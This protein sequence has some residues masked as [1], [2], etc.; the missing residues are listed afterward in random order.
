MVLAKQKV[1]T[2]AVKSAVPNECTPPPPSSLSEGFPPCR[3]LRPSSGGEHTVIQLIH[4]GDDD[5]LMNETRWKP[6]TE[7]RCPTL[8]DKC[9]DMAGYTKTFDYLVM[10]H[11]WESQSAP[12]RG[13]FEP[14]SVTSRFPVEH[15]NHQTTMTPPP[16]PP[17]R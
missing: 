14:L 12:A 9:T 13:R 1:F 16:P 5:Y 11:G 10:D 4:S 2:T 3:R 6:T 7:T 17:E 15:A 8:F